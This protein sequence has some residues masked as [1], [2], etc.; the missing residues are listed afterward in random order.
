MRDH[1]ANSCNIRARNNTDAM[2]IIKQL[3]L[4]DMQKSNHYLFADPN[5]QPK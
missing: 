3:L 4:A 2:K 1:R 5:G